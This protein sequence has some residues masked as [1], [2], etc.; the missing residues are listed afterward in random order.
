MSFSKMIHTPSQLKITLHK[1]CLSII[2][3]RLDA[4]YAS[5]E[6]MQQG[7]QN[8]AKSSMGDK[9]E[10]GREML[11]QELDKYGQAI[12]SLEEMRAILLP[13]DPEKPA[14]T[15]QTG[16]LVYTTSGIFYVSVPL[17]KVTIQGESVFTI[18]AYAPIVVALKEAHQSGTSFF[19]GKHFEIS[20]IV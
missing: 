8:D 2:G 17:G 16:A 18:S 11:K 7:A 3:E 6:A 10:T 15:I 13:I 14:T 20:T 5:T 4:L 1:H 19:R 9:Y 12:A